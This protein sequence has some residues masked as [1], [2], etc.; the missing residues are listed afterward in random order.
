MIDHSAAK[1]SRRTKSTTDDNTDYATVIVSAE[2]ER[3]PVSESSSKEECAD[4]YVLMGWREKRRKVQWID[5]SRCTNRR[6]CNILQ[7]Y[8][9]ICFLLNSKSKVWIKKVQQNEKRNPSQATLNISL[10]LWGKPKELQSTLVHRTNMD[11]EE[12]LL[13]S[14]DLRPDVPETS[15]CQFPSEMKET[16]KV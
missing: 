11:L 16:R 15:G 7:W 2:P 12:T 14:E 4:D 9:G 8:V 3:E 13:Q 10:H 6:M 5:I 1:E